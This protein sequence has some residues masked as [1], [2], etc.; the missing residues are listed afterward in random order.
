L[1]TQEL[2]DSGGL[3]WSCTKGL[4]SGQRLVGCT[5]S[6]RKRA[7]GLLLLLLECA[8]SLGKHSVMLMLLLLLLL[9]Y[10]PLS[11]NALN[12]LPLDPSAG[13][14]LWRGRLDLRGWLYRGRLCRGGCT[15]GGCAGCIGGCPGGSWGGSWT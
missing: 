2:V 8:K 9:L 7:I 10:S 3:E 4:S 15:R 13:G 12:L 14:S 11:V 6:L 1:S 5:V